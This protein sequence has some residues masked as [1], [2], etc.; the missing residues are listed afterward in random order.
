MGEGV[1]YWVDYTTELFM[2]LYITY[3]KNGIEQFYSTPFYCFYLNYIVE[4]SFLLLKLIKGIINAG[5]SDM[6]VSCESKGLI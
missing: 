6:V 2:F 5:K 1:V 4:S 3:K